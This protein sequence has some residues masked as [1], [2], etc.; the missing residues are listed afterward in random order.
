VTLPLFL[1]GLGNR[2]LWIPQEARNALIAREMWQGG[3]WLLPHVGGMV[4]PDKPPLLFWAIAL[5]STV[6]GGVTTWTARLLV[7]LASI[8]VCLGK[9]SH[10]ISP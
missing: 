9:C 4:Y 1:L 5:L 10:A 7:A 6:N 3:Q 8:A 2:L